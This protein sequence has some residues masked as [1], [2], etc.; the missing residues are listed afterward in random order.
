MNVKRMLGLYVYGKHMKV[1]MNFNSVIIFFNL[2]NFLELP[3]NFLNP[4]GNLARLRHEKTHSKFSIQPHH[5]MQVEYFF[6]VKW[7]SY[8]EVA[9]CGIII[10]ILVFIY[11][12]TFC[13]I[14]LRATNW[15]AMVFL[16]LETKKAII[17]IWF[18]A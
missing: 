9:N 17:I 11:S 1:S 16:Y 7:I 10:Y 14:H 13:F 3:T 12:H 15:Q 18:G 6:C 4:K 2:Y 5:S 8:L